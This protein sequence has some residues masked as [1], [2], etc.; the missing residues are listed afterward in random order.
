MMQKKPS[1]KATKIWMHLNL[2]HRQAVRR[3]ESTL[4]THSLPSMVW[5]D[6][7]WALE[8]H[9]NGLRHFELE[10]HCLMDQTSLSRAVKRMVSEGLVC[11]RSAS[12]DRRGRVLT[13]T[14]E[15]KA[16][17]VQMWGVYAQLIIDEI[18]DKIPAEL[19]DGLIEGLQVLSGKDNL[20]SED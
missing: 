5:Y 9:P 17:R 12:E 2:A 11:Q 7:L 19:H 20:H 6:A 8:R 13:I 10:R 14:D 1:D 15:G 4:K 18:E 3:F 16:L